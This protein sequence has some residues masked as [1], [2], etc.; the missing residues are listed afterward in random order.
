MKRPLACFVLVLAANAA[1]AAAPCTEARTAVD[2]QY[3]AV[4][5]MRGMNSLGI[6]IEAYARDHGSY[7]AVATV[8]ELRSL[9]QPS[10]AANLETRDAWGTELRYVPRPKEGSYVLVSAGSDRAFDESTWSEPAVSTDSKSDAVFSGGF[11]R[12]WSIVFP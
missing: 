10:Y 2:D 9:L 1:G 4:T 8:E 11:V 7:P 12:K 5:A 3:H 6:A